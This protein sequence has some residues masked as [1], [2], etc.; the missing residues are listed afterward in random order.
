MHPVLEG[1]GWIKPGDLG[2]FERGFVPAGA[3]SVPQARVAQMCPGLSA[4]TRILPSREFWDACPGGPVA[5]PGHR[6]VV[7]S[8]PRPDLSPRGQSRLQALG[9]C[10]ESWDG[11]AGSRCP[12]GPAGADPGT[13]RPHTGPALGALEKNLREGISLPGGKEHPGNVT[14][15][16]W[17]CPR[18]PGVVLEYPRIFW[19]SPGQ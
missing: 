12:P 7:T 18:D 15:G 5:S 9:S 2:I 17:G 1:S 14:V 3:G 19:G 6:G 10:S 8:L 16:S 13:P 4:R 11:A